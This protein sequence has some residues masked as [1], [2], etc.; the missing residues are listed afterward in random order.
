M[1][2][3]ANT[4]WPALGSDTWAVNVGFTLIFPVG[5]IGVV[6]EGAVFPVTVR[7][8][9]LERVVEPETPLIL[10]V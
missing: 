2:N 7:L 8:K 5:P 1:W 6:I 10:I 3:L 9:V 4:V